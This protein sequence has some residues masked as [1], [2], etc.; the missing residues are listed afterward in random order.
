MKGSVKKHLLLL[1]V[2]VVIVSC[3]GND[4]P[5]PMKGDG[6]DTVYTEQ[7]AMSIH[8]TNPK[9][10]LVIIDSAV[11]LGNITRVRG[12]YLKAVTQYGGL[13]DFVTARK[14]CLDLLED[15]DIKSDSVTLER[16]Y[17]LLTSIEYGNGN[18][19][20]I[21]RYASEASKLAHALNMPDQIGTMEGYIAQT[22][23]QTGRTDEGVSRLRSTVDYLRAIDTFQG[24]SSYHN[25]AKKLLHILL[26]SKRYADMVPICEDMISRIQEFEQHPDR[27]SGIA[28][29]FD[30]SEFTD[31][32][33]GQTYAFLSAAYALQ[34]T[35][36]KGDLQKTIRAQ[37][38]S[39][40]R[41]AE[42]E[43]FRTRW[44]QSLDCD[45]MMSASYHHL[46][47]FDRFEK[48]ISRVEASQ[49][50]TISLNYLIGL[51]LRSSAAEMQGKIVEALRYLRRAYTVR[52]SVDSRNQHDQ[53]NELATLYHLQEE[54]LARQQAEADARL[55][56]VLTFVIVL[57]F[58]AAVA[59]ASYFF[60]KRRETM[61][62]N[63]VLAHE[64]AEAIEYKEKYEALH[65]QGLSTACSCQENGGY[66]GSVASEVTPQIGQENPARLDELSDADLF[67]YLRG[68]VFHEQLFLDPQL[69][70]QALLDR[71]SLTKERIGAAFSKGSPFKSV[72]DFLNDCRLPYAAKLLTDHPDMSVAEVAQASGFAS[73]DTF[74][75]NFKQKYTLTPSQYR[76]QQQA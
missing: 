38:L 62:K 40:A 42:A 36:A 55:Y 52:D 35:E 33:R 59:F 1:F 61:K 22:L 10:A 11:A 20:A 12:T 3:S 63:R 48:A 60:Y 41:A 6:Q 46:G 16:V 23:A 53:L 57:G 31:Y 14:M 30:T 2:V 9:R 32:A 28:E 65:Q 76:E 68:V 49:N 64:I 7:R 72:I 26:E 47:E 44:S 29:G 66:C 71:F 25:I 24:V 15:K 73:A 34:A 27:F 45:R 5:S 17:L 67:Q 39:K 70:R 69:D 56:Q 75:R 50:D 4:N 58:I 43:V 13:D 21:I 18:A 8:R 54:Q 37:Y 19:A 74:G 51:E